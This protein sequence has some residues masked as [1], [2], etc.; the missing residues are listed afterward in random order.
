MIGNRGAGTVTQHFRLLQ[1]KSL[2]WHLPSASW[3]FLHVPFSHS[4]VSTSLPLASGAT[5]AMSG[6]TGCTAGAG[7]GVG[8]GF[9]LRGFASDV[10][11]INK[12]RM[13][14]TIRLN[15]C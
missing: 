8:A 11:G 5:S 14:R 15:A 6:V 7:A 2:H 12:V 3:H 4:G 1:S 13:N 9:F 10:T